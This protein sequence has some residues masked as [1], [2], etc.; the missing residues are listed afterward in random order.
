[1]AVKK[2]PFLKKILSRSLE[3]EK[4]VFVESIGNGSIEDDTVVTTV[5][6]AELFEVKRGRLSRNKL[7]AGSW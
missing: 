2:A 4:K 1:M 3:A 6:F 7:F 5:F